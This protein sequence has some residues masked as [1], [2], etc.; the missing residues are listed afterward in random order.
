M[1]PSIAQDSAADSAAVSSFPTGSSS[2]P[3]S[4]SFFD[5]N[6][7]F[8]N[9]ITPPKFDSVEQER[10]YLKEKLAASVRIFGKFGY[11]HHVVSPLVRSREHSKRTC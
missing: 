8:L 2:Q 11:D 5:D 3:N 1:A 10:A 9:L 7:E 4:E 6:S